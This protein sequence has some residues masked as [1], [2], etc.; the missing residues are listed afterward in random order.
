MEKILITGSNGFL[1]SRFINHFK[2]KYNIIPIN[3]NDLDITKEAD[4]VSTLTKHNA[5][6]VIHTAAIA[7]TG[8][9]ENNPDL[10]FEVNVKASLNIAKGCKISNSKLIYLSS[11]QI[12]NGNVEAGPYSETCTPLPN[13]VYG[14]HKLQ[15]EKEIQNILNDA[16]ILR[17]TWL[18]GVPEKNRKTN[19]NILWNVVKN[20]LKN[21]PLKL[22]IYEFRGMTY[23]YDI[24]DAFPHILTLPDGIYHTGSENNLSTYDT[25][26]LILK[27][28]GLEHKIPQLLIK[29]TEK[30]KEIPRDIRIKN[31]KL[32]NNN[33]IIGNTS[34][35]IKKC[36]KDF[37]LSL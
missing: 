35:G 28:M 16:V 11:E 21:E 32:K 29:D 33:I 5:D 15:A 31:T 12:Y 2:N 23:I 20:V 8:L 27:E 25:A 9:C 3:R 30:Y 37:S 36:I 13:T 7:D 14:K 19:S 17:L 6:Y 4:V 34:E 24:L 1:A 26:S 22:P 18:F 10:S